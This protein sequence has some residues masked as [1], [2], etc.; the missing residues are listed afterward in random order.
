MFGEK[1]DNTS[2][3]ATAVTSE[4]QDEENEIDEDFVPN[5]DI[6]QEDIEFEDGERDEIEAE[7]CK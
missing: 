2:T 6:L 5:L 3:D 1:D 4:E 7:L